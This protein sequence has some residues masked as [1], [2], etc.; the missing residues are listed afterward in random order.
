MNNCP[1]CGSEVFEND[2]TQENETQWVNCCRG[3]QKYSIYDEPTD[4]QLPM[5][6]PRRSEG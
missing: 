3:C 4:E 6:E 1:Y 5:D 2:A